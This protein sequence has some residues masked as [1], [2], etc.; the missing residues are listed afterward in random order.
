MMT[1]NQL[2]H[3][4]LKAGFHFQVGSPEPWT[5][6]HDDLQHFVELITRTERDDCCAIVKDLCVSKNNAEHIVEVIRARG[7]V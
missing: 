2:A 5:C 1:H 3:L 4:A 7:D 6:K